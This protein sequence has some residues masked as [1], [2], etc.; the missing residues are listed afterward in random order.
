MNEGDADVAKPGIRLAFSGF[1]FT[2]HIGAGK[3]ADTC[4]APQPE[5]RCLAVADVEPE[6]ESTLGQAES[7]AVAEKPLGEPEARGEGRAVF[8]AVAHDKKARVV[9]HLAPFVEIEAD[10]VRLFDA[11]GKCY[12]DASGGAAVSCL[13]HGHRDVIAAIH[14][15]VDQLAYAHTGFFGSASAEALADQVIADLAKR[16]FIDSL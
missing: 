11:G 1:D 3:D 14:A 10:G 15:Q 2:S 4:L 5:G 6:E 9:G 13:G 12:L 8:F 16:G 7:G